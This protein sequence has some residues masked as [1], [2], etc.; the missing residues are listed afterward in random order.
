M[1]RVR[2]KRAGKVG[3]ARFLFAILPFERG[4]DIVYGVEGMS[5]ALDYIEAHLTEEIDIAAVARQAYMSAFHF[6]RAFSLLCGF[7]PG[8]YIR[9]RRLTLA[10][11][12][13]IAGDDKIIDIALRCGYDAPD[14]FTRAFTRFHGATP[15]AVRRDGAFVRALAP[16][17]VK[18]IM[19]GGN[20]MEYRIEDKAAFTVVGMSRMFSMD[21]AYQALPAY[22]TEHFQSGRGALIGGKYGLCLDGEG[23]AEEFRYMIADD[24]VPSREVPPGAHTWTVPA[25]TWAVFPCK[26][27]MPTALQ[28]VNTAIFAQWLPANREY[29]LAG[30]MNVEL[31]ANS[32]DYSQGNQSPDYYAEIWLP[33]RRKEESK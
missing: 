22:W 5:R 20:I 7:P 21:N 12:A 18:L 1:A 31:Y 16:L 8:D 2:Q 19:E 14:S 10:A 15:A 26:G 23:G 4:W 28:E 33:V 9:R 27:P 32:A 3:R 17:R 11:E 29:V 30:D 6:Q 25:Q 13:L 24:Y